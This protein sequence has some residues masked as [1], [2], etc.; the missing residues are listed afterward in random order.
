MPAGKEVAR[1]AAGREPIAAAVL[2]HPD[3]RN[4]A[5][6]ALRGISSRDPLALFGLLESADPR[7]RGLGVDALAR[8]LP[9]DRF[10]K[11]KKSVK[12]SRQ[13]LFQLSA[14]Q[15][16]SPVVSGADEAAEALARELEKETGARVRVPGL[17]EGYDLE[18]LR[19]GA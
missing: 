11:D 1:V 5:L 17:G 4:E 18:D 16:R 12:L 7:I 2:L 6:R 8:R 3:L 14:L 19:P 15:E 13:E 9:P 10:S